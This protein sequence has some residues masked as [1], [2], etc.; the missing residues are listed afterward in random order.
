[1]LVAILLKGWQTCKCA[2]VTWIIC[3]YNSL[4]RGLSFSF[5][6]F[7]FTI[8]RSS[9]FILSCSVSLRN[10][11]LWWIGRKQ[12]K[13]YF[14]GK[15]FVQFH[16]RYHVLNNTPL[17]SF[18]KTEIFF[19]HSHCEPTFI[20]KRVDLQLVFLIDFVF[21]RIYCS[22]RQGKLLQFTR[23]RTNFSARN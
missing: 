15:Y 16:V 5:F 6:G 14:A 1:M 3:S 19:A 4:T 9:R 18:C 21:Y 8:I 20:L 12:V 22:K 7:K 17:L 11:E 2:F 13:D 10:S 23:N